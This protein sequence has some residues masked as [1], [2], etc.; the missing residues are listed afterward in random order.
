[1]PL[2]HVSLLFDIFRLLWKLYYFFDNGSSTNPRK[3]KK[4]YVCFK[5]VSYNTMTYS[6]HFVC[7]IFTASRFNL[8]SFLSANNLIRPELRGEFLVKRL[9]AE[10]YESVNNENYPH[11]PS[12]NNQFKNINFFCR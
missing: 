3:I 8:F 1:M 10:Y 6:L 11:R 2:L 7:Y 4:L 12:I 9:I 5:M